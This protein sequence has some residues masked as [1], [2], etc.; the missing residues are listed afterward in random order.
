MRV[1]ADDYAGLPGVSP[2]LFVDN[3]LPQQAI[4]ASKFGVNNPAL[5][6]PD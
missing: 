2:I 1:V 4:P 5:D 3:G 6:L